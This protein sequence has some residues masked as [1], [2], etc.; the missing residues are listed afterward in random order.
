ME[1]GKRDGWGGGQTEEGDEDFM[2]RRE[3]GSDEEGDEMV[4]DKPRCEMTAH[5]ACVNR[6]GTTVSQVDT[7]TG[8]QLDTLTPR[9]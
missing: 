5:P 6:G 7:H 9:H 2:T 1:G 3:G 4:E 8:T